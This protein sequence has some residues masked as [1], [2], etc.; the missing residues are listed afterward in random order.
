M[1]VTE[2]ISELNDKLKT[3]QRDH[4]Q[5]VY[6]LQEVLKEYPEVA[7]RFNRWMDAAKSNPDTK[8][9]SIPKTAKK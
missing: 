1:E 2:L 9:K 5:T 7:D 4:K 6:A 8:L 3:E